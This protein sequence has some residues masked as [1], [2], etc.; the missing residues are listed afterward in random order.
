MN[1]LPRSYWSPCKIILNRGDSVTQLSQHWFHCLYFFLLLCY[2]NMSTKK[3]NKEVS[4]L[5]EKIRNTNLEEDEQVKRVIRYPHIQLQPSIQ[6]W[7]VCLMANFCC[8]HPLITYKAE[9]E[10]TMAWGHGHFQIRRHATNTFLF[11]F[12][13]W[14]SYNTV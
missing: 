5:I 8:E 6:K 1:F 12:Y 10:A 4:D 9:Q 7:S 2:L 11:R 14:T 13:D 3:S